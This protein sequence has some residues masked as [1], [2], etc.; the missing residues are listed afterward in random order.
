[1]KFSVERIT[2]AQWDEIAFNAHLV[3]FNEVRPAAYNTVDFAIIGTTEEDEIASYATIIEMDKETAYMQHGG[4]MPNIRGTVGTKRMYH[5]MIQWLKERYKRISTRVHATNVPM[6]KLA[7]S[8][9]LIVHGCDCYKDG[10]Y[11]HLGWGFE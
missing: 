3:L 10:V 2:P 1:M 4:A 6:L 7:M 8:E 9:G 11:V 5:E